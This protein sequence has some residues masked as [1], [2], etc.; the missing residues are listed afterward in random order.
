MAKRPVFCVSTK[1]PYCIKKD[2]EFTYYGGF[3]LQQKQKC[4]YS[5][6]ESYHKEFPDK[7]ILEISTKSPDP[8]GVGLS[9]FNLLV[10]MNNDKKYSVEQL[11]QSSKVFEFGGPYKDL[12]NKSP[13]EA[14]KDIR[15]KTSG[16]LIG[17]SLGKLEFKLEPKTYFYNWLY[18]NALAQN[19]RLSEE[20]K[21]YEAFTDIEFNPE[22]SINCQA[23]AA[24]IYV[25]LIKSGMLEAA[26]KSKKD[27]L[28]II[29]KNSNK[30]IETYEQ[31][32][33]SDF[34]SNT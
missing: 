20:I 23:E 1:E 14:K 31:L 28:S 9:A 29:Y 11:F 4:V 5:L 19:T 26:L 13:R 18:I 10:S 30:K 3:S 6:H 24:A 32:S 25:G 7:K 33:I 15:L 2:V 17:F 8:V 21:E 16:K 12:L 27:F 22:K 34:F